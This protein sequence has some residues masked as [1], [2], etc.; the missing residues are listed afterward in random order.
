MFKF[1]LDILTDHDNDGDIV[2][3]LGTIA[4]ITMIGL[5]IFVT[6][7]TKVFDPNQFGIGIGLLLAGLGG[8]YFAKSKAG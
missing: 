8:G 3:V 2:S 1:L 4:A 6:Y 5:Q 7:Q